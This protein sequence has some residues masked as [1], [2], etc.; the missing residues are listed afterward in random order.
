MPSVVN[1]PLR[2]MPFVSSNQLQ[3]SESGLNRRV[4]LSN[5]IALLLIVCSA[6]YAL[7]FYFMGYVGLSLLILPLDASFGLVLWFNCKQW[8]SCGRSMVLFSGNMAAFVYALLLG[9]AADAQL[10]FFS[11]IGLPLI[12]FELRERF[13]MYVWMI[14][15]AVSFFVLKVSGFALMSNVGLTPMQASLIS[16][17]ATFVSLL[18]IV[19][20][21]HFLTKDNRDYEKA[22]LV[23]L[24]NVREKRS[25]LQTAYTRLESQQILLKRR[26]TAIHEMTADCADLPEWERVCRNIFQYQLNLTPQ[27]WVAKGDAGGDVLVGSRMR[28]ELPSIL[29]TKDDVGRHLLHDIDCFSWIAD[30]VA[31]LLPVVS[32]ATLQAVIGLSP[33]EPLSTEDL[34]FAVM[35]VGALQKSLQFIRSAETLKT[36]NM[37]TF[38][39]DNEALFREFR[40]TDRELEIIGMLV[41]GMS[42]AQISARLVVTES[43]T[44][45]HVYN[46]FQ[47]L[48][49]KSRFELVGWVGDRAVE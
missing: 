39:A 37:S 35:V 49:I 30:G 31:V 18:I 24:E 33:A 40:I 28:G 14:V 44:K 2:N 6:P 9:E 11:F 1:Q 5:Q 22:Y 20:A 4:R 8:F 17:S 48:G 42:N 7:V 19:I 10:L 15:P 34:E 23:S 47:K 25:Q 12:I 16:Y 41:Q 43:T 32:G 36:L 45:R 29:H 26:I 13:L 38:V 3:D 46:I 27:A 21:L